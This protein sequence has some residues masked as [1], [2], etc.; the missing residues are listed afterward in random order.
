MKQ[1]KFFS[2]ISLA[3]TFLAVVACGTEH[4]SY[5]NITPATGGGVKLVH[6]APDLAGLDFYV[7]DKKFT[8]V[9]TTPP[10][11]PNLI[12]YGSSYPSTAEYASVVAGKTKVGVVIPSIATTQSVLAD[13][14]I[15]EG[16]YYSIFATG[17]APTY[18]P[19]T[20]E[21]KL[22]ASA[23]K[24][25]YVR[26]VNLVPN[27][28]T[29][30]FTVNGQIIASNIAYKNTDNS[31][32]A[33]P[34]PAYNSGTISVPFISKIAGGVSLATTATVNQTL[35]VPGKAYTVF[36]RG[37]LTTDAKNP[38]KFTPVSTVIVNR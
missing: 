29:A 27:S 37:V 10:A 16:K 23:G 32:V 25:I 36:V 31:F 30:E 2:L 15:E 7:N 22:P 5:Q 11:V 3:T 21:D 38:T 28:T 18:T 4:D 14:T 19:F 6:A 24:N 26:V 33:V 34:I 12:T 17:I 1:H 35:V 9:S 20:L 13:L 8:G